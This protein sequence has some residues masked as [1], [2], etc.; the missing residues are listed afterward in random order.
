MSSA[1][2]E[3]TAEEADEDAPSTKKTKVDDEVR[4][5]ERGHYEFSGNM[6]TR[7]IPNYKMY[8]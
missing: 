6:H 2:D 3:A 8:Q 5:S 4:A 1:H 7:L